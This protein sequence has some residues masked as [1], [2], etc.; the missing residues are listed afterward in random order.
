MNPEH[1]AYGKYFR[2]R[3]IE[4]DH[5]LAEWCTWSYICTWLFRDDFT[6]KQQHKIFGFYVA[7]HDAFL[8]REA[9]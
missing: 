9:V 4:G 2:V 5:L 1:P 7:P 3:R 6:K 8:A